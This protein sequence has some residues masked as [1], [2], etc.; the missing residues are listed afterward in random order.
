MGKCQDK[1]IIQTRQWIDPN[2]EITIPT[3]DYE[4]TYP[5]TVYD[6]IT[7]EMDDTSTTLRDELDSI[8][9]LISDKQS[10][11]PAGNNGK[12]M[13]FGSVDGA[14]NPT[15]I[16]NIIDPDPSKRS[17]VKIPSE[18]A[19]GDMFDQKIAN[20]EFND[21]MKDA[22][23]HIT[24]EERAIWNSTVSSETFNNHASDTNIHI[25]GNER[26]KWNDSISSSE[27]EDHTS[28]MNNPHNVTA[29][30]IGTYS[31]KE[32]DGIISD[33][34]E[35]F[36]N[37]KN[38]EYDD[39]TG[40]ATLV[41]YNEDN[42]N[43]NYILAY[44][45]SFPDIVDNTLT[46]FA[47]RPATDYSTNE[48]SE[49]M[50]FIKRPA[51][52]SWVQVGTAI[53]EAGDM[54]LQYPDTNMFAWVGGRF[55]PMFGSNPGGTGGDSNLMWRPV[56]SIENSKTLLGWTRST[57]S[58]APAEVV[59]SGPAG[60]TPVKGIDYFD[61]AP[62]IGIPSGGH[63]GEVLV[64]ASENDYETEWKTITSGGGTASSILWDN[65]IGKPIIYDSRGYSEDGIMTQKSVTDIL[66]AIEKN[67]LDLTDRVGP[68]GIE[69][70][71]ESI[72]NHINDTNNPHGITA[73]VIGAVS[74]TN[75]LKHTQNFENPHGIT[76]KQIGL[77]NVDN[78]RDI[79]KPISKSTQLAIDAINRNIDDLNTLL[80]EGTL[81]S[82][83]TWDPVN[84][85]ITVSFRNSTNPDLQIQLPI[86]DIFESMTYDNTTHEFVL[87]L[88]DGTENRISV[89]SLITEYIGYTST[90]IKTE[91]VDGEIRAS[92]VAGSIGEFEIA[93]N[94]N[95]RGIPTTATANTSDNSDRIATTKFAHDLVIDELTS[96]DTSRPLSANMGRY[97]AQTKA[98]TEAVLKMIADSP[99]LTV[100]DELTSDSKDFALSANM[101]RY[102]DKTKAP[103]VHTDKSGSVY[104]KA[105]VDLFGHAKATDIEPT[106][107]GEVFIGTDDGCYARGDH[108]HPTDTSRAPI[109]FGSEDKLIG[110]PKAETPPEDS[111]DDRIATTEWVRQTSV[112][113]MITNDEVVSL[114]DRAYQNTK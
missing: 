80:N 39:R 83:L 3:L 102:L 113:D 12:L 26:N 25:T 96:Y 43:P 5:R 46:Y 93:E 31:R 45:D 64:K 92:I 42:W 58:N 70:L 84:C 30:Q 24:P 100:V 16:I 71:R 61:G 74:N 106:M 8:Y 13:T 2:A 105:T 11:I 35:S 32:I 56:I 94:V 49:A 51:D 7:K 89:V 6:A 23:I 44:A 19:V 97:L 38:I 36:F 33:L 66:D 68:D 10:K 41:E 67:V 17:T 114:V 79:D 111:N 40:I 112:Y 14:I 28:N 63:V 1:K 18:K 95:L 103:N 82:N 90:T 76:P 75:F 109:D 59:I 50:I 87:T 99:A 69:G 29:H 62:G 108:K 54:L 104:G 15:E 27:F 86:V 81:V 53:M 78:T 55:M 34:R 110:M 20:S 73:D 52:E 77:E 60:K 4:L 9:R 48:S 91:I 65:I 21:H 85:I 107:N 57:E 72:N 47:I 101:G 98:D 88:P 22:S 37:R